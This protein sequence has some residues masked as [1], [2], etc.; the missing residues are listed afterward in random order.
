MER[1]REKILVA[2]RLL[3][4]YCP[5]QAAVEWERIFEKYAH[6]RGGAPGGI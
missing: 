2:L 5:R 4:S 3:D 1:K 6:K